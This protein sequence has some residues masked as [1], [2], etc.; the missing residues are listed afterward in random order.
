M[1][2]RRH[3]VFFRHAVIH[4]PVDSTDDATECEGHVAGQE[5]REP[6]NDVGSRYT[7]G[8]QRLSIHKIGPWVRCWQVR[9]GGASHDPKPSILTFS[10]D[11]P[12][13]G[14]LERYYMHVISV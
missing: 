14:V 2:R 10:V 7:A 12:V 5:T 3:F 11:M 9:D 6:E 1:F 8:S 13:N 4:S